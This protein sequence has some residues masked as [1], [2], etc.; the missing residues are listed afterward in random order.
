M[1]RRP[2]P[3]QQA[4]H[5][6]P[7][8]DELPDFKGTLTHTNLER[9]YEADSKAA[10]LYSYFGQIA[11]IEG[12]PEVARTLHELA[13]AQAFY[14]HG[15]LD[16][17]KRAGDP[18]TGM[19]VGETWLNL[20]AALAG[21][22]HGGGTSLGDMARTAHAEGFPDIASWFETL[23]NARRAHA[24]RLAEVK[25]GQQGETEGS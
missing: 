1:N 20:R 9:A 3:A 5:A 24:E 8:Q 18:I 6:V 7:R 12:Y 21:Q 17:L 14:A 22:T 19:A 25:L 23:G 15:H 16:F 11:R 13:E 2:A 4:E 10:Q